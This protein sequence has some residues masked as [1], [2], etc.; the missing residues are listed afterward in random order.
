MTTTLTLGLSI[1]KCGGRF[2]LYCSGEIINQL[3]VQHT[4]VVGKLFEGNHEDETYWKV[5][6]F[7]TD[8]SHDGKSNIMRCQTGISMVTLQADYISVVA[9]YQPMVSVSR[10]MMWLNYC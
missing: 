10:Y 8:Q 4:V 7:A 5:G 9:L 6:R 2:S 3:K 1:F